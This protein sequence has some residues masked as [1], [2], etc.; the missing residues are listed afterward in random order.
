MFVSWT[1]GFLGIEAVMTS[2]AIYYHE[3]R[4]NH[5]NSI[6]EK[7]DIAIWLSIIVGLFGYVVIAFL[8][9]G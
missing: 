5:L 7:L 8:N 6:A 4:N 3:T 2:V 1:I 9:Q